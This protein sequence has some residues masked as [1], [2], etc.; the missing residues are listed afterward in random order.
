MSAWRARP[1]DVIG[2][3]RLESILGQGAMGEV[4]R[5]ARLSDGALAAIK[6]M[7][8]ELAQDLT[9]RRRFTNEARLAGEV[10]H[11][12]LVPI[13]QSGEDKGRYYIAVRYV[14][15]RTLVA[16]IQENGPLTIDNVIRVAAEVGSALD[17]L[18][19][20][21]IMHRDVKASNVLIDP[22][23]AAQLTDFGLA[24][25]RAMTVLTR[26][27]V[28]IG[29]LDYLAPEIIRGEA[30]TPDSDLYS[31]A[32][33][34]YESLTGR[35]PFADKRGFA[36]AA[37]HLTQEPPDPRAARP[38][39]NAGFAMALM[40]ALGKDPAQRPRTGQAFAESLRAAIDA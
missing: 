6:L 27:G 30:A 37:A 5:A 31:L 16:R 12:N 22:D 34:V 21:G 9:Y 7:R 1:G 19:A 32:C 8:H 28:V 35:T 14:E 24:K 11:P 36:M 23:G 15:G 18:H 13:I 39:A 10:T 3:Y 2:G 38:E 25:G 40:A 26:P 4:F 33:L 20:N 17:A 29:T